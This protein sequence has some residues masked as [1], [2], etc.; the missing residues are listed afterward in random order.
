MKVF[1]YGED[2]CF[3]SDNVKFGFMQYVT[4]EKRYERERKISYLYSTMFLKLSVPIYKL[5]REVITK[6]A[7]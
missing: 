3:L 1:Y 4:M 5:V 6:Q 2:S 7:S